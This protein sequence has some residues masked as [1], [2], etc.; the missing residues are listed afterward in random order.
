MDFG[1]NVK[2]KLVCAAGGSKR[3]RSRKHA[4]TAGL[5]SIDARGIDDEV[6][7][8]RKMKNLFLSYM[9]RK[10]IYRDTGQAD[11]DAR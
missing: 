6:R 8:Y 1:D 2:M 7:I 10:V 4:E 9:R 3:K 11:E 5:I